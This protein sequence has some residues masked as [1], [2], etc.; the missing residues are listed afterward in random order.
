MNTQSLDDGGPDPEEQALLDAMDAAAASALAGVSIDDG[1]PASSSLSSFTSSRISPRISRIS[2]RP[3]VLS[4]SSVGANKAKK[5][6]RSPCVTTRTA[7]PCGS[8]A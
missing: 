6:A 4:S 5:R 1:R 7:T 3:V 8:T 2:S